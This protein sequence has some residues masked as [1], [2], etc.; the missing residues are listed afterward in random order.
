MFKMCIKSFEVSLLINVSR[1]PVLPFVRL[2]LSSPSIVNHDII[3]IAVCN[4]K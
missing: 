2:V 3:S 1:L 4:Q